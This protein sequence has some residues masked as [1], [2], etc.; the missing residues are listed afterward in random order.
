V[1][2]KEGNSKLELWLATFCFVKKNKREK[3]KDQNR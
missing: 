3:E 1:S 2:I